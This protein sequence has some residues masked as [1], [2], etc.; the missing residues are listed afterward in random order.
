MAIDKRAFDVARRLAR[1]RSAPALH[2]R[3]LVCAGVLDVPG[4]GGGAR[5]GVPFLD[6]VG[7][8]AVTLRWSRAAGLPARWPDGLGLALRVRDAGGPDIPLDLLMTSSGT[9]RLLRHLPLPRRDALGGPYSTLLAYRTGDRERVIAAFPAREGRTG[10]P[11]HPDALRRALDRGPLRLRLCAAA[12][13]EPWR[14]FA[15]LTVR[16]PESHPRAAVPAYDPYLHALP[17]LRPT[18]RLRDLRTAAYSGSR[19]GRDAVL[20]DGHD[21]ASPGQMPGRR[22]RPGAP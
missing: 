4:T 16:G 17:G 2:P 12:P 15:T 19:H 11:G 20:A 18:H 6:Q 8:Y 22:D 1:R 21:P 7:E 13:H 3:G 9:G 10:V 14:T 5:W